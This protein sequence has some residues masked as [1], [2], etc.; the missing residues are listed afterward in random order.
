MM[1]IQ[2]IILKRNL[3]KSILQGHPWIYRESLLSSPTSSSLCK[4]LDAKKEFLAWGLYDHKSPLAIRILSCEEKT[5]NESDKITLWERAWELKTNLVSENTNCF[6]LL[7][8]EGDRTPGLICD[9]YNT[10][11]VVQFDSTICAEFWGAQTFAKW[12]KNK[13]ANLISLIEK[14]RVDKSFNF[15]IGSQEQGSADIIENGAHFH[16]DVLA[17]QKTGFFLDQRD[18]RFYIR[19][20]AKNKTVLNA[21]SYTG[22]FS[23]NAGLG[24]AKHVTS[25]DISKGALEVAEQNWQLNKL[26]KDHHNIIAED[27]YEFIKNTQQKWQMIIVDPPSMTRSEKTKEVAT[28]KYIEVFA[29]AAKKVEKGGHLFLSSCSSHISFEDFMGICEQSLSQARKTGQILH[30]SGQGA[31]HP[32]PHAC[33]E[34]R[35]LKFIH[36]F[37]P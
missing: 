6:R 22:G 30:I 15:L 14:S 9:I 20:F 11:A 35:Y 28:N 34:L 31:D 10:I 16:V 33:Q 37:L 12:L 25:L 5:P 32:F 21:F 23:I 17:G 36:I 19:N 3:R 24:G 1:K 18:N 26:A 13:K 7:N 2:N 4:V 8:G 27:A 29:N